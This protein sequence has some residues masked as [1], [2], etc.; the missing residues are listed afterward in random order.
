MITGINESRT[1]TKHISCKC[2]CKFGSRKCNL[3]KKWNN[4]KCPCECESLKEHRVCEKG[5]FWNLAA[6]S[7]KY[8]KYVGSIN[9]DSVVICNEV[10]DR[11][12]SSSTK[13][14]PSKIVP[15]KCT[16]TNF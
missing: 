10:I 14:I 1:L 12:K 16:L 4:D 3:N 2:E 13:S 15:K 8:C 5:Y 9:D 6:C 7:C 11:T